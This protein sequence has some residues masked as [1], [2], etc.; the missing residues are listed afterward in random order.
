MITKLIGIG[1][2]GNKAAICAVRN[3]IISVENTMLINSTLKD[4]PKDYTG[5]AIEFSNS[6]GGCGKER[7]MSYDLCLNSIQDGTIPLEEFLNVGNEDQTELV[8]LVSSTVGGTGSGSTPLLAKYIR[9]VLGIS[10]HVFLFIG[11]QEDVRGTKNTVEVFQ[12][13]QNNF[14]TEAVKLKKYLPECN[15]NRIKA[16]EKADI[17]FCKKLS[18]LIG[19]QLR[20]SDHNIDPTDL[21]K[22]ST[23]D[24]YMVIESAVIEDKI[25][26][27]EQ[28]RKIVI[29]MIDN[30]KTLDVDEPS[31]T[32]L[33]VVINIKK[34][35]T[36][37]I[38]YDDI[39]TERFGQCYDKFEHIQDESDMD[40]FIAFISAG[41]K[42]PMGEVE[43]VYNKYQKMTAMVNKDKDTFFGNMQKKTFANDDSNFDIGTQK[44]N[45]AVI[46]KA[47]FFNKLSEDKKAKEIDDEF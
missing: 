32:R 14:A 5:S 4:I 35:S 31:Q 3:D 33:A 16:E 12:E 47:N 29:D 17:D 46:D 44:K 39:L 30:S 43:S 28:F 25:K 6:Y 2:G 45:K 27:R 9:E 37:Y 11:F 22:I 38:D 41:S 13:L 21:L 34:D 36:D 24:G 20:D 8:V 18:V 42:M 26:N 7:Q 19:L 10:V 15:N 1:A 23:T 40:Q